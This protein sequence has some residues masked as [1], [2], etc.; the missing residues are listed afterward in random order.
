MVLQ[1]KRMDALPQRRSGFGSSSGLG[2][3]WNMELAK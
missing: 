3:F 1:G 2:E